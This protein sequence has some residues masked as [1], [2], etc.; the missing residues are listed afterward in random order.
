MRGTAKRN[1]DRALLMDVYGA[2]FDAIGPRHWW[3]GRTRF[4]VVVGAILTQNTAWRNVD[5]AIRNLRRARVLNPKAMRDMEEEKLA[6]LI[7]PAGYFRVKARRLMNF[8]RFLDSGYGC[9]LDR[10]FRLDAE[11][12]R[13]E[14][15]GVNGIGPETADSIVLYAAGKPVFVIDAYTRRILA[16]HG[17]CAP[18]AGYDELQAL[19]AGSLPADAPLFNEYH[20][21]LVY[22]GNN[23]CRPRKPL[24]GECPLEIFK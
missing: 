6:E 14:L 24:C 17:W 18:D 11:A 4:E 1:A 12:L 10:L 2:M 20:A 13:G 3:P 21:L 15:L 7:V 5:R 9:S 23:F 22:V 16:R 19:F 8:L